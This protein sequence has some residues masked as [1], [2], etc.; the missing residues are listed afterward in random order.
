MIAERELLW[1][2]ADDRY[3]DKGAKNAAWQ[4]IADALEISFEHIQAWYQYMRD[5]YGRLT[6]KGKSGA[7]PPPARTAKDK[8]ILTEFKF[9]QSQIAH[10]VKR[11]PVT[12]LR[13]D[14]MAERELQQEEEQQAASQRSPIRTRRRS[15]GTASPSQQPR[16]PLSDV[17]SLHSIPARASDDDMPNIE[18]RLRGRGRERPWL[19]LES[20][21]PTMSLVCNT[22]V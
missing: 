3:K 21:F 12:V 11:R 2:K 15:A 17:G 20:H 14:R 9:C 4:E 19:T 16:S 6:K 18:R 13:K 7:A 22:F 5:R 1:N 10:Q 8:W